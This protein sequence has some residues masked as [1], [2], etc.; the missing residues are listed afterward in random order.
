MSSR[1]RSRNPPP[2]SAEI[3]ILLHDE[4]PL[5][6]GGYLVA[7][8][9]SP[10]STD[11]LNYAVDLAADTNASVTAIH[12]VVP[13]EVFTG[14]DVPPTS[15]AEA[16][17]EL[18]LTSVED[19]ETRGQELL[20]DAVA[21]AEREGVEIETGLLYG[22]PVERITEFAEDNDFDAIFVGHRGAS[23]RYETLFGSVAKQVA[24][25]ATVPVTIVR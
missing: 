12:V 2:V 3:H 13:T 23:E 9:G 10:S 7:L 4:L 17:R 1:R 15:F 22:E 18:L 6:M 20:D 16:D 14:G 25:R 21:S 5:I 24:G 19:A 11:A 8:D